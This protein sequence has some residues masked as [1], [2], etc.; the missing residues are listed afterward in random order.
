MFLLQLPWKL[1]KENHDFGIT[2]SHH[3][4]STWKAFNRTHEHGFESKDNVPIIPI[5]LILQTSMT[6]NTTVTHNRSKLIFSVMVA[7]KIYDDF[8]VVYHFSQKILS[9]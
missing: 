9:S 8:D 5:N 4:H 7:V 2:P 3:P 6:D 1:I